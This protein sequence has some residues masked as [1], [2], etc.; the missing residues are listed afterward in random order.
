M[1]EEDPQRE[2]A[3]REDAPAEAFS[4]VT[5]NVL[6]SALASPDWFRFCDPANLEPDTRLTR[7]VSKLKSEIDKR[8]IICLQEVSRDWSG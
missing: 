1:A 3:Q 5:Y 6:S 8:A 4:V 7:V 2:D